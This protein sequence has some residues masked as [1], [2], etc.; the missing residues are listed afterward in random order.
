MKKSYH[1]KPNECHIKENAA[2]YPKNRE[3]V[4]P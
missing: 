3:K 1:N 4:K 2:N